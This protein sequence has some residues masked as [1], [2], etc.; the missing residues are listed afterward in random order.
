MQKVLDTA[1]ALVLIVNVAI[2]AQIITTKSKDVTSKDIPLQ[3]KLEK[4]TWDGDY[5]RV[6]GTVKNTGRANYHFVKIVFTAK[7]A[8]GKFISRTSQY[9]DPYDIEPGQVGYLEG[10]LIECDGTRP[11]ALEYSVLGQKQ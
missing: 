4:T 6:W 10:A 1:I 11:A 7:D 8:Q 2:A 9:A 3:F 5:I